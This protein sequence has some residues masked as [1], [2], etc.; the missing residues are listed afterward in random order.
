MNL[1]NKITLSRIILGPLFLASLLSGKHYIALVFLILNL[2]GDTLDG[3]LARRKRQRTKFGEVM[4]PAVDLLFFLFAGFGFVLIGY[5]EINWF[6]LPI[7][8]LLLSFGIS[9]FR[10]SFFS[11][12]K[13]LRVFHTRTKY[14]HTPLILVL[15]VLM[16]FNFSFSPYLWIIFG[17]FSLSALETLFRTIKFTNSC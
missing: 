11:E 4:D 2:L 13:D 1:A 8:V 9:F 16:L 6:L 15:M 12:E 10:K 5:E 7:A 3:Y 14:I 17:F